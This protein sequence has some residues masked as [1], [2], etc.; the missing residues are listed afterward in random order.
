MTPRPLGPGTMAL[1]CTRVSTAEKERDTVSQT[2]TSCPL[3][4]NQC[5]DKGVPSVTQAAA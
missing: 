3:Y 2:P 5:G 1:L 4:I